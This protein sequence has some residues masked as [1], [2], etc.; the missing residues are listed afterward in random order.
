MWRCAMRPH[1]ALRAVSASTVTRR[2]GKVCWVFALLRAE[3]A[4]CGV[5]ILACYVMCS[6]GMPLLQQ[7]MRLFGWPGW[8][9]SA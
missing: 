2:K 7:K 6:S 4:A 9:P 8:V 5:S 1:F 3:Q